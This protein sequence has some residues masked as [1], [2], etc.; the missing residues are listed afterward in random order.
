MISPAFIRSEFRSLYTRLP[1]YVECYRQR[2]NIS[3]M[4]APLMSNASTAAAGMSPGKPPVLGSSLLS[5]IVSRITS[6]LDEVPSPLVCDPVVLA[7][8]VA[9]VVSPVVVPLDAS[10]VPVVVPIV[11]V[12]VVVP[13]VVDL[14]VVP[15]VVELI[16]AT[17]NNQ[18]PEPEGNGTSCV[19]VSAASLRWMRYLLPQGKPQTMLLCHSGKKPYPRTK[20]HC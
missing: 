12:P 20:V 8:L 7:P 13:V 6:F 16:A 4:T 11:L 19:V 14:V 5:G 1:S 3:S 2:M 15:A 9:P 18:P 17:S 10:V